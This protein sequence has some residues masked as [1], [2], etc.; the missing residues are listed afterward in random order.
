MSGAME[1]TTSEG[2]TRAIKHVSLIERETSSSANVP[3]DSS[4]EILKRALSTGSDISTTSSFIIR[5][6]E[7]AERGKI[8]QEILKII[9]L[10][11]CGTVFGIPG[12]EL[13]CKKGTSDSGIW[14]DFCLTNRVYN[15][16][17]DVQT[18]LQEAFP[19]STLPKTPLCYDFTLA[20]NDAFWNK[21]LELFP[22]THRT[23]QALFT[24]D[25]IL[26]IP[27]AQREA[28]IDLYFEDNPA[29]QHSARGDP[30]NKDCLIRTYLGE[31]EHFR[32]EESDVYDSLRNFPLRLNMM[33]DLNLD[34]PK[35]AVEMAIGLAVVHWQAQVDGMDMEFVLGS[36]ATFDLEKPR[37]YDDTSTAPHDVPTINFRR[38]AI[39]MWMLDFD[40]ATAIELIPQDITKKLV[41]AFLGNDPYFPMPHTDEEL[42]GEFCR[43]YLKASDLILRSKRVHRSV[44]GLPQQFLDEVL[45]RLKE[46]EN[47]NEEDNIVFED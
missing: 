7:A 44:R 41:P 3:V 37:G 45:G 19:Q 47:W 43:A 13:A 23:K 42:W 20:T 9:G 26:P 5:M 16:V 14:K 22:P 8:N 31:R 40:K 11:S 33:E 35:L 39:H 12:T 1:A 34:V 24:V 2:V 32:Q 28:L 18:M 38:R 36:S 29:I 4:S 30:D 27:E 21:H 6:Q 46:N 25:R 15:A 17:G 10:G